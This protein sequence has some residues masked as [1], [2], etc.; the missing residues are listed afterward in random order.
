[1]CV[2]SLLLAGLDDG[3]GVLV[4]DGA[5]VAATGLD[6]PDDAL[7]LDIIVGNLAEDDVLAIEPRGDDGGDEELGAVAVAALA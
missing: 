5:G 6:G 7:G 1:V 3:R 2:E 4:L